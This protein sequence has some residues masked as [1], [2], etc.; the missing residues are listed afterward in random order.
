MK[1]LS[2]PSFQAVRENTLRD[3]TLDVMRTF[4]LEEKQTNK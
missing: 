1:K 3:E 4:D 2:G